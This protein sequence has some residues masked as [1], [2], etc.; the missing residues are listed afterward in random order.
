MKDKLSKFRLF[1]PKNPFQTI[2][3]IVLCVAIVAGVIFVGNSINV[4]TIK[5]PIFRFDTGVRLDYTGRTTIERDDESGVLTLKNNGKKEVLDSAPIYFSENKNKILLP[6]QKIVVYPKV[7]K[8]GKSGFNT[9]IE[10]DS[11]GSYIANV[12]GH[13]V[14][15]TDS[16]LYDG[17][18]TY[19]FLEPM[20]LTIGSEEVVMPAFSYAYVYYNLRVE[21]YTQDNSINIVVQTG[22]ELVF[23]TPI[24]LSYEIDLSKDILRTPEGEILL[25][26][27]PSV[28]SYVNSGTGTK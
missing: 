7:K 22:E 16:F 27:D 20:T 2:L 15:V 26:T 13:E 1:N 25:I 10:R 17:N 14:D 19:V 5:E 8:W 3:P 28:L 12:R 18:N 4:F 24:D 23:A 11:N 9:V 6:A 21:L